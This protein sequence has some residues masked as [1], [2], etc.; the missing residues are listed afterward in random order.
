MVPQNESFE[1]QHCSMGYLSRH[2]RT[3]VV[4]E[5]FLLFFMIIARLFWIC[6]IYLTLD[7]DRLLN[8]D[9]R[10]GTMTEDLIEDEI[11]FIYCCKLFHT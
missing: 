9:S 10:Q 2:L 5:N 4:L 6:C 11:H 7:L 1:M 8:N 3:G